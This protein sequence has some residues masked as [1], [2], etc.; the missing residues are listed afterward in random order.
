M[1]FFKFLTGE[2]VDEKKIT[3]YLHLMWLVMCQ[4]GEQSDSENIYIRNYIS[5]LN[6]NNFH[7]KRIMKKME[8]ITVEEA[9]KSAKKLSEEEKNELM[10]K[11]MEVAKIDGKI[12]G[13]EAFFIGGLAHVLDLDYDN[14]I[15][16]MINEYG[17]DENDLKNTI[18]EFNDKKNN[19]ETPAENTSTNSIS[20]EDRVVISL[21]L[22]KLVALSD[23]A[24]N[25]NEQKY[26]SR[27]LSEFSPE[28][29][30]RLVC[31]ADE[32]DTHS[33]LK[34]SLKL[35][36]D[37]R[38][39]VLYKLM[40]LAKSDGK[41]DSNEAVI[42][43]T[44]AHKLDLDPDKVVEVMINEYQLNESELQERMNQIDGKNNK[45]AEP[46]FNEREPIGFQNTHVS[47]EPQVSKDPIGFNN[48]NNN[49][50]SDCGS[51]Q[52]GNKFCTKCGKKM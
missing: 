5:S 49:N 48:N 3:T 22:M 16:H 51:E 28:E 37:D 6:L 45:A 39:E 33:I 10:D 20:K 47:T 24:I 8:N 41:L 9:M 21:G 12:D 38:E 44:V 13:K 43:M 27:F 32:L 14:V 52:K 17:L 15:N 4:D 18:Q 31:K 42:I 50:C 35:D 29:K 25:N 26:I 7:T 30:H 40:D 1:G 46:K 36:V 34:E 2:T 11:L 19:S 23:E